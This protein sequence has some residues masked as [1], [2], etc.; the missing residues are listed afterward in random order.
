MAFSNI[1]TLS[2][3]VKYIKL[4]IR[5]GMMQAFVVAECAGRISIGSNNC[6]LIDDTMFPLAMGFKGFKQ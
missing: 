6:Q 1:K 5:G 2:V 4:A 3:S